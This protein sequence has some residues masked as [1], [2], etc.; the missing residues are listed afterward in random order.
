MRERHCLLDVRKS[1][2]SRFPLGPENGNRLGPDVW[3]VVVEYSDGYEHETSVDG[4]KPK[5]TRERGETGWRPAIHMPRW[6]SRLTLEVMSV[7][8]ERLQEISEGD[9]W[10]EGIEEW[11]KDDKNLPR[12]S[13]GTPNKYNNI[14]QAFQAMW[15]SIN[16]K[17]APWAS[18]P[19]VWVIEF[20]GV[21]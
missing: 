11:L 5:Q 3:G 6:A 16:A 8:V 15:N 13:D 2:L 18:N 9:C 19:W 14:T 7:R 1:A 10:D 17:R 12:Y 20:R 21:E 4:K